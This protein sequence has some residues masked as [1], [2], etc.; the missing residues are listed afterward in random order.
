MRQETKVT[1]KSKEFKK[2]SIT[3]FTDMLQHKVKELEDNGCVILK[4]KPLGQ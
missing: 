2:I 4:T 3:V 1:F